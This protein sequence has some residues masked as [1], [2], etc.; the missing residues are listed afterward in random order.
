MGRP[1]AQSSSPLMRQAA[2]GR[3][4]QPHS[5]SP[6]RCSLRRRTAVRQRPEM[7]ADPNG[8]RPHATAHMVIRPADNVDPKPSTVTII[9]RPTSVVSAEPSVIMLNR[10]AVP[11]RPAMSIP[12]QP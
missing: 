1:L 6:T 10:L 3:P 2:G 11:T 8:S 12:P 9:G 7:R 5:E 4:N